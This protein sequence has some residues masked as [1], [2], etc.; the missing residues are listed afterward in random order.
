MSASCDSLKFARHPN[1]ERHDDHDRLRRGRERA[2]RGR[3]FS[4][5]AIDRGTQFGSAKIGGRLIALRLD[6]VEL[7][8][9]TVLLRL[10]DV[11][12]ALC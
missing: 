1:V 12:L 7:R 11:D 3:Q 10:Q 6:L 5:A 4:N 8:Q 2:D 9:R